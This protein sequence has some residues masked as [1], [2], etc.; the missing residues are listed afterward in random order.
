MRVP[1]QEIFQAM[2]S[3]L[4]SMTMWRKIPVSPMM[5]VQQRLESQRKCMLAL[6]QSHETERERYANG[7][8]TPIKE[9]YVSVMKF[10]P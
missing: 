7:L 1:M 5:T 8:L 4:K 6:L 10:S 9:V 2:S 3:I